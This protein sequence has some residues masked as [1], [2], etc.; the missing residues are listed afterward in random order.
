MFTSLFIIILISLLLFSIIEL[1]NPKNQQNIINCMVAISILSTLA[2]LF[3]SLYLGRYF[4]FYII[5]LCFSIYSIVEFEKENIEKTKIALIILLVI[6]FIVLPIAIIV[7]YKRFYI[8]NVQN[9]IMQN[10]NQI[11]QNL[12]EQDLLIDGFVITR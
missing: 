7:E 3:L 1:D 12:I 5:S 10:Q 4:N 2:W 6:L 11:I 8:R 9:Q